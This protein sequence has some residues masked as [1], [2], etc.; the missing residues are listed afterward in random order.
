M[1]NCQ[2]SKI[3][4][5]GFSAPRQ[6]RDTGVCSGDLKVAQIGN[7]RHRMAAPALGDVNLLVCRLFRPI[8]KITD[9]HRR[10]KSGIRVVRNAYFDGAPLAI[11]PAAH[12]ALLLDNWRE[13]E[14]PAPAR[15]VD[16]GDPGG[17]W[18]HSRT[19]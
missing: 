7:V 5:S 10:F 9:G 4:R 15:V 6:T 17:G 8:S 11:E 13:R 18:A 14:T 2:K 3:S 1:E 19:R 16:R 12:S